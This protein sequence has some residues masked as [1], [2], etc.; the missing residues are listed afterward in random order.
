MIP[1]PK[2][3]IK[4]DS[5]KYVRVYKRFASIHHRALPPARVLSYCGVW[6]RRCFSQKNRLYIYGSYFFLL[7]CILVFKSVCRPHISESFW[8]DSLVKFF[9]HLDRSSKLNCGQKRKHPAAQTLHETA[10]LDW[11]HPSGIIYINARTV[12]TWRVF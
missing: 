3:T 12:S 4:T 8:M 9:Y 1:K 7:D 6:Q 5:F 2:K 11:T 10:V